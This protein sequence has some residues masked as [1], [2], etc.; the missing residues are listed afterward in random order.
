M[1]NSNSEQNRGYK[2][3]PDPRNLFTESLAGRKL[4]YTPTQLAEEFL[5]YVDDL[6]QSQMEVETEYLKQSQ[7]QGGNKSA[8]GQK[9]RQKFFRPPK[10]SDFVI[11]WLGKSLQWWSALPKGKH[12]KQF[13]DIINKIETYCYNAKLDGAIIWVYNANIIAREL[14]LKDTMRIENKQEMTIEEID[15]EIARL[16]RRH[17]DSD[18]N[19]DWRT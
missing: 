10:I 7:R 2:F 9:R 3:Y 18:G 1:S 5:Q 14:G 17:F 16:Q 11:R 6:E 15:K 4:S 19:K 13:F 8:E 12:G